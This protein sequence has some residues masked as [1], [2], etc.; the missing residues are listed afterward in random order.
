MTSAVGRPVD[1]IEGRCKVTGAARYAADTVIDGLVHGVLVQS[2][3]AKGQVTA[4]SM[5]A[6]AAAAA[7]APG[8]LHVLTPLNCPP[9]HVLPVDMTWDL[10]L[11]RRPPLSDLTVQHVGQH[12]AVVIA[13]T[14]EQAADAASLMS[15]DYVHEPAQ[16][17]AADVLGAPV[18]AD[19]KDGQIRYGT[20][21]PDHFVKLDEE[22]L[23]DRRGASDEPD[24][25]RVAARFTTPINAHYPIELSATVAH[26]DGDMLTVH[27]STRW[28]TGERRALAAYLGIDEDQVRI[29]SPLVGGAFGSKSF[30]WM[31]VVL[32]AVAARQVGRPVKLVLTRNQMFSS[33]G[34]RPRTEQQVALVAD[35]GGSLLSTEQHTL[36]ETSTV[37][38]FCEP[39]GLTARFLY[40]SPRMVVS[41]T[42]ARIN[43][44]TPCF[45]RGPGEAPGMFALEVAMDELA[46]ATGTDPVTL[47][48]HNDPACDQPSGRAW[49]GKHLRDCY[50][51]GAERFGWSQR[52]AA[53]RAMRR[54]GIQVGWGMATASY[55]GRRMASGCR[56]VTTVDGQIRFA[57]A[58]HE[59]GTGVRTVMAQV[60]ADA[61]GMP[62]EAVT[63]ES[64]D[65]LFPDAPYSGAS[66]TTATVGSAVALAGRQWRQ[67]VGRPVSSAAELRDVLSA[68]PELCERLTFTVTSGGPD[69]T[70]P[71][72]QSFGAHFCE[73]EVDEEIGRASVTRWTAVMDCGRVLN[74]KLA[75]NQVMGGITFGLG[76]ALLEQVPYDERTGQ[77]IGEY[78]LPTHADRPDFDI[79][80][81]D[82]PDFGLDPIGVRGIGEIGTCGVPAAIANAVYHAT[83][84]RLRDLPI[85]LESLLQPF[86]PEPTS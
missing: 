61:T 14:L 11:E 27:D 56:V 2:T 5:T 77:L 72:S 49:S 48:L 68:E 16:L 25:I 35:A 36:T 70:G 18:P 74:P 38:H 54:N 80:F 3:V 13:E 7:A 30:L 20:Y 42:V 57:A 62:L 47:R 51:Q 44:P 45:M 75:A 41:H 65:S 73:V 64:G 26:W 4:D 63:F 85:T 59:I 83:G 82:V 9:L 40:A 43:A 6:A 8:V 39:V 28:I 34:H 15:F 71:L 46:E 24:G 21:R 60:G 55:P 84:K 33:T 67:R 78:Y 81:I 52:P 17:S 53:P 58:T 79:T 50:L 76:M 22:K 12:L 37:A 32:C 29:L 19:E 23:Q 69:E 10:P 31:H 1:R 86:E 66:Q